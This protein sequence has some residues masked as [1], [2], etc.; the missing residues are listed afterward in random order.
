M[1]HEYPRVS[2]TNI[3]N[4]EHSRSSRKSMGKTNG[5]LNI[6]VATRYRSSAGAKRLGGRAW[7]LGLKVE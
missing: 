3:L 7:P 6:F 5:V 2:D 1:G 4:P